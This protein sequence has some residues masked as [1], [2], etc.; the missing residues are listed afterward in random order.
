MPE[1]VADSSVFILGMP[2]PQLPLN[3]TVTTPDVLQELKD[4]RSKMAFE[5]AV[6]HGLRIEQPLPHLV[7]EVC[8]RARTTGDFD[9]LSETDIG[10]LAKT[11][12]YD[13]ILCTDDYAIQNVA[14][15]LGIRTE[16]IAQEH[17][18]E[19]FEWGMRCTGCGRRFESGDQVCPIC[20]SRLVGYRKKRKRI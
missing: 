4:M 14:E 2:L 8:D 17:I 13:G 6:D 18:K 15:S 5:A 10:L 3:R 1:Y 12:E 19:T 11:L 9:R 16:S 7:S 20:G